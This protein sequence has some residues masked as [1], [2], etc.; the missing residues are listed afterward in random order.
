M[1]SGSSRVWS[2]GGVV[3]CVAAGWFASRTIEGR[4]SIAQPTP[5]DATER[6]TDHERHVIDLFSE[7]SR[8]LVNVTTVQKL[9][10]RRTR[11]ILEREAGSGSGF[12]WDTAG[13]IVT[14]AHVV[15]IRERVFG[16]GVRSR[17]ADRVLVRLAEGQTYEAKVVGIAATKDL[18]VLKIEAPANEL[19]PIRRGASMDLQVGQ[20]VYA[21]G[22]PFG[23]NASLST[24]VVSALGRQITSPAGE[25]IY[26]VIQ[27]DAAVNPG[28]SGGPLLDSQGRLIG[29]NAAI[30]SPSGASA[31]IGFAVPADTVNHIVPQLI[32]FGRV[33]TP[34]LGVELLPDSEARRVGIRTGVLV[35]DLTP[36]GPA[37]A[38]GLIAT[39]RDD[40]GRV[41]MGDLILEVDGKEVKDR[42]ELLSILQDYTAGDT[43]LLR[44]QRGGEVRVVELELGA[45]R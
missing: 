29:V 35:L 36:D 25:T 32:E 11:R 3:L 18:A 39:A 43:V 5:I 22:N 42:S 19:A 6:L 2:V 15:A 34:I 20:S 31:G 23:L 21:I 28:N 33:T 40:E 38:A 13:H 8:S 16:G 41:V 12:V 4:Q 37:E 14:N 1:P 27:T 17:I 44:V 10:D 7:G 45:S 9:A 26:D 24:G 30:K